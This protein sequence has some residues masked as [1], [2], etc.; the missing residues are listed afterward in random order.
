MHFAHKV[1]D[2]ERR[3]ITPPSD[4]NAPASAEAA[5][6]P[7][8]PAYALPIPVRSRITSR[9]G[10]RNLPGRVGSAGRTLGRRHMRASAAANRGALRRIGV[11]R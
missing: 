5:P 8:T 11:R 10:L 1:T 7:V 2:E 4:H 3:T 6:A 9:D